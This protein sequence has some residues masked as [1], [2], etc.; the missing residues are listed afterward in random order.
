MVSYEQNTLERDCNA[1]ATKA[2][3][4]FRVGGSQVLGLYYLHGFSGAVVPGGAGWQL[5]EG[6]HG[7][8]LRLRVGQQTG[9]VRI[10]DT[11]QICCFAC[12]VAGMCVDPVVRYTLLW[13]RRRRLAWGLHGSL[14]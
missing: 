1:R 9:R 5:E 7:C 8:H 12:R 3:T 4:K 11:K 2:V 14:L 6:L 10:G 13:R